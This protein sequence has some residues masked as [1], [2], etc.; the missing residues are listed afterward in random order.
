M[1]NAWVC[2]DCGARQDTDG[3]CRACHHEMTLDTR[4]AKVRELMYDVDLRLQQRREGRIRM[5]SVA[6]G[7]AVIFGLWMVPG[8]WGLRGRLSPG[9]PIFADQWIAMAL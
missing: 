5:V 6:I 7:M 2:I 9:L 3:A 4:D 8:Y 1:S